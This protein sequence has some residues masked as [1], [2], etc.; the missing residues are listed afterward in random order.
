MHIYIYI[1][2]V[3][4]FYISGVFSLFDGDVQGLPIHSLSVNGLPMFGWP[5]NGLLFDNPLTEVS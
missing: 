3:Y 4:F 1:Y 2:A 5:M